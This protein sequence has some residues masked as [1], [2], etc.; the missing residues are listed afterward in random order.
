MIL[1]DAGAGNNIVLLV[2]WQS[3]GR[4]YKYLQTK[5]WRQFQNKYNFVENFR[6]CI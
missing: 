2:T 6:P 5:Y 3:R 4:S 1:F